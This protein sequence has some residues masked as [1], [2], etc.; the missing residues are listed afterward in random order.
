MK[1][2]IISE[3]ILSMSSQNETTGEGTAIVDSILLSKRLFMKPNDIAKPLAVVSH[4]PFFSWLIA[5]LKPRAFV[6]L[7]THGGNSYFSSCQTV[8]EL[9][10]ATATYAVDTWKGDEH[11]GFYSECVYEYV[12]GINDHHYNSFSTLVRSTFDEAI[13]YFEDA[14]IDLLHIDGLHTY[15]AVSHDFYSWLTKLS[16]RAVVLM[17]DTN[18]RERGFGVWRC[19]SELAEKYPSFEFVHGHGL[20]VLLVG[21]HHGSSILATLCNHDPANAGLRQAVREVFSHHGLLLE[22]ASSVSAIEFE[23]LEGQVLSEGTSLV[24]ASL[25]KHKLSQVEAQHRKDNEY[26]KN[27]IASLERELEKTKAKHVE[28]SGY[29]KHA[30]EGL[31]EQERASSIAISELKSA[32]ESKSGL[33]QTFEDQ[34]IGLKR[35]IAKREQAKKVEQLCSKSAWIVVSRLQEELQASLQASR[36][37]RH[38]HD[39]FLKEYE[40]WKYHIENICTHYNS[41]LQETLHEVRSSTSW[42][43]MRTLRR[44]GATVL[45]GEHDGRLGFVRWFLSR[46]LPVRYL[47]TRCFDPLVELKPF[48]LPSAPVILHSEDKRDRH[49]SVEDSGVRAGMPPFIEPVLIRD[50]GT[51]P[52]KVDIIIPVKNSIHWVAECLYWATTFSKGDYGRV[53][54]VDDGSSDECFNQLLALVEPLAYVSLVR[55]VSPRGFAAAC[56][57][58]SCFSEAEYLLFLNSDCML[59]SGVVNEMLRCCNLDKTIGMVTALSN[60]AANLSLDMPEGLSFTT[61]N[62]ILQLNK[63]GPDFVEACTVVGHCLLVTRHCFDAVGGFDL[64]WGLGYG[65]E[66]DLQMRAAKRGFRAVTTLRAY[67]Y[68]FGGGTFDSLTERE[69]LQS[70]NH[71]R[72]MRIWG[73]EYQNLVARCKDSDPVQLAGQ[74]L[75][76]YI[77]Q[78]DSPKVLFVLPGLSGT[79]GGVLVIVDLCNHLIKRGLSA[80]IVILG[81]LD[82]DALANFREP[83]YFK[84]YHVR[85]DEELFNLGSRIRPKVVVGTLFITVKPAMRLAEMYSAEFINFVQGYEFYFSNGVYYSEV[86]D[87]YEKSQ[88]FVTTSTWL[89]RGITRHVDGATIFKC[90]LGVN[91]YINYPILPSEQSV[92]S[93]RVRVIFVL[94]ASADKG[95]WILNE[96]IERLSAFRD[97]LELTLISGI[98]GEQTLHS[99]WFEEEG[100]RIIRLPLRRT[101]IAEEFRR[102]HIFVDASLHEGFGLMPLEALACGCAVVCSSS[103]GVSDFV[104]QDYNG[105]LVE[106]VTRPEDYVREIIALVN[107]RSKLETLRKNASKVREE[108]NSQKCFERYFRFFNAIVAN[109]L[110]E[111]ANLEWNDLE[112]GE[113]VDMAI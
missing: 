85:T 96:V 11:A 93:P 31:R 39:Q 110:T 33:C 45:R 108:F 77:P 17:H 113:I 100:T 97:H 98:A 41:Q 66:T 111:L 4:I 101:Q 42:K 112:D 75:P 23:T 46:F 43:I 51:G 109:E 65:E 13:S 47:D 52:G 60:S 76:A 68:H 35:D 56:N 27:L 102:A 106:K 72:F 16:D 19:F 38:S 95:Q 29:Y 80:G 34:I 53:I 104:K 82:P 81:D 58:G 26:H 70:E 64:S 91:P 5:E 12:K 83:I 69:Q 10:L 37:R 57:T 87:T 9:G 63:P 55:N 15:E 14:S 89:A 67:V 86:R 78:V 40:H 20:G 103:G 84:P 6:E 24:E 71:S 88:S 94:R 22:K 74:T 8:R 99:R 59:P 54:L 28:D 32:L 21:E 105:V 30:I 79:V 107:N 62:S 36:E 7:G 18:V 25:L 49:P 1:K 90:P 50:G 44:F 92:L 3:I 73:E 48:T 2:T 61:V